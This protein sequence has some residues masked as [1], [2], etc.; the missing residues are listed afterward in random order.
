VRALEEEGVIQQYTVVTD[1]AKLGYNSV[2]LV[3]I[4]VEPEHLLD[5]AMRMSEF[6]EVKFV[7]TSA[8]DHMNDRSMAYGWWCAQDIHRGED[9]ESGGCAEGLSG[10]N[11]GEV[12]GQLRVIPITVP[13]SLPHQQPSR[14]ALRTQQDR[15][16][17]AQI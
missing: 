9:Q 1:P 16:L 3:G 7:A 4:D 15:P 17:P 12:K 6:S 8:G 10:C 14:Q 13:A 5:V 2:A 11:L